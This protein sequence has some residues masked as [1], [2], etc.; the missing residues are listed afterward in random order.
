MTESEGLTTWY[1]VGC[2]VKFIVASKYCIDKL[3]T[4]SG[5]TAIEAKAKVGKYL[6]PAFALN[7]C[8]ASY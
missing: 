8:Q 1:V 4:L 6:L 3:C 5:A 2:N 7:A